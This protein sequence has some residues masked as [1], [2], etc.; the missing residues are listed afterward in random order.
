MRI[1]ILGGGISGLSAAYYARQR[2]PDALIQV[3]EATDRLGGT[4]ATCSFGSFSYEKGP[5]TF[6]RS[7]AEHLLQLIE[8]MGLTSRIVSKPSAK[9][10]L[11]H[12]GALRTFS[13]IALRFI[14]TLLK[15]VLT[16][17]S[18][19]M[20]ES[21]YDFGARRLSPALADILLDP[22]T[23]G[24]FAGDIRKLSIHETFPFLPAWEREGKSILRGMLTSPKTGGLFT[25]QGGLSTLVNALQERLAVEFY[26]NTPVQEIRPD[27]VVA[28][29][30]FFP[31]DR[32]ISALPG[33]VLG[34]LTQNWPDFP[35]ASLWVIHAAFNEEIP[36]CKNGYGYLIPT[37]EKESVMGVV[38]D[39]A[40]FLTCMIRDQGDFSWAKNQALSA[41]QRHLN[42]LQSPIF[43][44]GHLAQDAIP[45]FEVGYAKRLKNFLT[46]LSAHYP[47]LKVV[48]N[49]LQ[50]ASVDACIA[51][52]KKIFMN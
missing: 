50:G 26:Y 51:A 35:A 34:Q 25:L 33:P 39:S 41:L 27:G 47:S 16:P 20:D 22:M 31:G 8:E 6:V 44:D 2:Y 37:Q 7:R 49:Y 14:P 38:F 28:A 13:S 10:Y 15:E 21:I 29:G 40:Q 42:I 9:R 43:L 4:I 24:I 23:L 32:M 52:S 30:K 5:R 3:L 48:G 1:I 12:R 19:R 18:P 17:A 46:A 45:Q 11:W 36:V